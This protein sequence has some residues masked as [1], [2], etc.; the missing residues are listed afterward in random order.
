MISLELGGKTR[1]L[2]FDLNAL[3]ELE[4]H[5]ARP[6]TKLADLELSA[7]AV[8]GMLWASLLHEEPELTPKDVG[9]WVSG[10]NFAEVG[11]A[12]VKAL[13]EAF[14]S[15]NGKRPTRAGKARPKT[16]EPV[17]RGPVP[18]SD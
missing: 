10:E 13:A 5:L 11:E 16:G 2:R 15:E 14:G 4:D 3:A 9:V 18:H 12:V 6:V 1:R 7:T 17:S 8:R